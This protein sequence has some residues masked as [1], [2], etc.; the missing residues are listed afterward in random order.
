MAEQTADKA[1][2]G[3]SKNAQYA[4]I[5]LSAG[6]CF[7]IWW[8][9]SDPNPAPATPRPTMFEGATLDAP[10]TLVSADKHDLSCAF[11]NEVEGYHCEFAKTD[12]PW[13]EAHPD[14]SKDRK[15]LLAPYKTVD[16]TLFLIAGLFE[17]PAVDERYPR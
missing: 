9:R 4:Y 14:D 2:L 8:V 3:A 12:K 6:L 13:T 7:Y 17:E 5:A 10:V 16:D 1:P 11:E 15:K